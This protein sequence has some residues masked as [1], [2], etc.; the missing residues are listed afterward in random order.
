M[1]RE[2][3]DRWKPVADRIAARAGGQPDA[4]GLGAYDA[5]WVTAQAYLAAGGCGHATALE[6]AFVTA[7]N[8]L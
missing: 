6:T 1:D 5:V 2:A 4:F 7:A 8:S 3:S